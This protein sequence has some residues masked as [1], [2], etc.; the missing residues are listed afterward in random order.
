MKR[1]VFVSAATFFGIVLV[2]FIIFLGN[3]SNGPL[4][5]AL[6]DI[7]NLVIDVEQ[8]YLLNQREPIRQKELSWFQEYRLDIEKLRSPDTLLFGVFDNEYQNNFENILSFDHHLGFTLPIL[9][10][11]VAW[12]DKPREKFPMIYVKSIHDL[13]SIPM[14]TWEPW[15]N[16]FDRESHGLEWLEDP[17]VEGMKALA[18]GDYDFYIEEWSKQVAD[19]G[20]PIFIRFGH[21]M[22]DPYRYPWGPQNNQPEDFVAAWKHV[23]DVFRKNDVDNVIW[24]WAPQP[25]HLLYA[26][27]YP[28]HDYVDW[29]G[30]GALNYGTVA[31]W[32]QWWTFKEIF[33]DYYY[34]L[35]MIDKPQ[36]ITEMGSLKVGGNRTQW[37]REA[38]N[39]L[40]T[41]Y[42]RIKS[43]LFFNHSEDNT[44]FNK[45]LD[46]SIAKDT[47]TC[48][49][50]QQSIIETW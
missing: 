48:A 33:G 14:I 8:D 37:F 18:N 49:A 40:P 32:S 44:T 10:I 29:V 50:I 19:F 30:V 36:M 7:G 9:H 46:W 13:G 20:H 21:E 11:Y 39:H 1:I 25:S 34:W 6:E 47:V 22:N 27:Y 24:I 3:K 42:P 12:G 2:L 41:K 38:F 31:S 17:N 43:I 15:L 5:G 4:S 35:D 26:E 45:S 23:I 28:G 16:D